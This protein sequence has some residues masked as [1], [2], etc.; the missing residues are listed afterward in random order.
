MFLF[1]NSLPVV[2]T[3][4]WYQCEED[5][6]VFFSLDDGVTKFTDLIQ[7]VE[8]YQLNRGVLPCKLKHPC[9]VVALWP[10]SPPRPLT[11]LCLK[12]INRRSFPFVSKKLMN[13]LRSR[14]FFIFKYPD[15]FGDCWPVGGLRKLM[16]HQF[17]RREMTWTL[18]RVS[19]RCCCNS[20]HDHPLPISMMGPRGFIPHSLHS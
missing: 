1:N 14:F 9:T 7:L 19:E 11:W 8:F 13:R 20:F 3:L 15:S 4:S 18:P 16:L 2:W 10:P 5:G 6:Q 12:L 17:Q